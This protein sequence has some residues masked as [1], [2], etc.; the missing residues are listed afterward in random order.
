[1]NFYPMDLGSALLIANQ[2]KYVPPFD[3]YDMTSD[4]DD[5]LEFITLQ[6]WPEIFYEAHDGDE[7]NGF[8]SGE[9]VRA[10]NVI[11]IGLG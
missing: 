6:K 7:L 1:M 2:W 3:F 8:F 5:Y 4:P 10:E 9:W 11:E